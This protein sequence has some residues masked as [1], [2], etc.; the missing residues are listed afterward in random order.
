[1]IGKEEPLTCDMT[2]GASV[3][4]ASGRLAVMRNDYRVRYFRSSFDSFPSGVKWLL[5]SN[6]AIF[7]LKLLL[8]VVGQADA[9]NLFALVPATVIHSF[10][11]WQLVTYMFLHGSLSHIL[12]NLLTLYWFGPD[13]E[14]T[15]GTR[16]FLKFYLICGIGA[17]IC[18]VLAEAIFGYSGFRTVG[19]SGAI[20]GVIMAYG[21]LF[22]DRIVLFFG[23]IPIKVRHLVWVMGLLAF[24]FSI[25]GQNPG[26]SDVAHL[27]GLLVGYIYMRT[28]I[29]RFDGNVLMKRY[30]QWKLQRAKKKFQVYM[31]KHGGPG[32]TILQ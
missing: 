8:G 4:L 7:F 30:Q 20:Y 2:L 31:R 24:Y 5:I 14:R 18:V 10:T 3:I 21:L 23:I 11:V 22:P 25:S 16:R 12:F 9:L 13:L 17:G 15:W 32:G 29:T 27:G 1:M 19:A 28:K 6:L 26:V